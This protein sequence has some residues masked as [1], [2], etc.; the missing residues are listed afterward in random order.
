MRKAV[1]CFPDEVKAAAGLA[2]QVKALPGKTELWVLG[3]LGGLPAEN[4]GADQIIEIEVVH[5]AIL[6]EPYACA[7]AIFA[8]FAGKTPDVLITPAGL[9]GDELAAQLSLLAGGSCVTAASALLYADGG[10]SVRRS[11]YAGNLTADFAVRVPPLSV[12]LLPGGEACDKSA[13]APERTVLV[14]DGDLPVWLTDAEYRKAEKAGSLS[15]AKLVV[16]AGRGASGAAGIEKLNQLAKTLGGI[17]GGSRPVIC[18]GK[19]PPDR[20]LG[21]SGSRASPALCL[22]FGASGAAAFRAGI[23]GSRKIIAVNRDPQAPIF[24]DCDLGVVADC[25]EFAEA[26]AACLEQR[27][28]IPPV[29]PGCDPEEGAV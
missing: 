1:I 7:Q 15:D 25:N 29:R 21:L 9:R 10:L 20:Q 12:S 24:E 23:E 13:G 22:V 3:G 27:E 4:T 16:A 17:L 26:L 28:K 18:A 11:V 8:L 14:T 6:A 19:L 2:A 5:K